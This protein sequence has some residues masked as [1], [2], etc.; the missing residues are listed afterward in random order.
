MV[1]LFTEREDLEKCAMYKP[2]PMYLQKAVLDPPKS[3]RTNPY[4]DNHRD[5]VPNY[6][7]PQNVVGMAMNAQNMYGFSAPEY[8]RVYEKLVDKEIKN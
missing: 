7:A 1:R 2:M 4:V 8:L 3:I 6:Q 5:V